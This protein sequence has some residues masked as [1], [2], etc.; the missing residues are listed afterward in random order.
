[1]RFSLFEIATMT[2]E[3]R[4]HY[5]EWFVEMKQKENEAKD[6]SAQSPAQSPQFGPAA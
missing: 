1:M 4:N 6:S 3:E 5:L 2:A